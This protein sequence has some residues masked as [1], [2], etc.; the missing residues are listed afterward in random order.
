MYHAFSDPCDPDPCTGFAN[1]NMCDAG[2]CVCGSTGGICDTD[3]TKPLCMGD[4]DAAKCVV[5]YICLIWLCI[6][7]LIRSLETKVTFKFY[8][9]YFTNDSII[10]NFIGNACESED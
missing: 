10:L 6:L 4:G 2:K 9:T 5:I 8:M 1:V 7:I 3:S